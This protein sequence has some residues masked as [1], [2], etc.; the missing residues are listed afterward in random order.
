MTR[1]EGRQGLGPDPELYDFLPYRPPPRRRHVIQHLGADSPGGEG[2][3]LSM[4]NGIAKSHEQVTILFMDIVGEAHDRV[5]AP[6]D[7][8][9]SHLIPGD[10]FT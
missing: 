10:Q 3:G 1:P 6:L 5:G 4:M 9:C 2:D 8:V 7:A